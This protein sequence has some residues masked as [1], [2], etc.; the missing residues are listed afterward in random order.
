MSGSGLVQAANAIAG[1]SPGVSGR[2]TGAAPK[3]PATADAS[4]RRP[5]QRGR[6]RP[7]P[8]A[9]DPAFQGSS[10]SRWYVVYCRPRQDLRAEENL[11]R[12]G[13]R[14]FRP[15]LRRQARPDAR[16][17]LESMFPRYLFVQ[18][19][20]GLQDW[21]PIRSTRGAIG[22][23][24][25]GEQPAVVPDSVIESLFRR[26][27]EHGRID[28]AADRELVANEELEVVEGPGAGLRA[29]Y[30]APRGADRV[31]VLL[32]LLQQTRQ[33]EL[34]RRCVQPVRWRD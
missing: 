22:L 5:A 9:G 10:A 2:A 16:P 14:V 7:S 24:R 11:A 8:R 1:R 33:I 20:S 15:T 13:Y 21:A 25:R 34:P 4:T 23:V 29:L 28:L 18:L 30:V 26:A 32:S 6:R 27:D 3:E 12:Q 31:I 19:Q 17:R